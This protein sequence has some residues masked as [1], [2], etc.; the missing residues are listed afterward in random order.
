MASTAADMSAMVRLERAFQQT[1]I[2]QPPVAVNSAVTR[3]MLVDDDQK[4]TVVE[5]PWNAY[6]TGPDAKALALLFESMGVE[7]ADDLIILPK[8]Q[9]IDYILFLDEKEQP[10]SSGGATQSTL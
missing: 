4:T 7:A 8:E 1:S 5:V 9:K 2:T 6:R 3:V 10:E